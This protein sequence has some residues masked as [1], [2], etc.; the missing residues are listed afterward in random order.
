M[1]NVVPSRVSVPSRLWSNRLSLEAGL[2]CGPP[3][4]ADELGLGTERYVTSNADMAIVCLHSYKTALY[5]IMPADKNRLH[6]VW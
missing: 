5:F 2:E 4:G 3:T 6:A 1:T